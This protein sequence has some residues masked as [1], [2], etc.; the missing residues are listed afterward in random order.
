MISTLAVANYQSLRSNSQ[1]LAKELG[2]TQ[3]VGQG[4]LD[5]PAW[6]WPAR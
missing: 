4:A 6:Q 1:R 5:A 3:I 2:E